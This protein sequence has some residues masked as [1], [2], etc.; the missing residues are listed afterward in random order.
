[1]KSMFSSLKLHQLEATKGLLLLIAI[2]LFVL[3]ALTFS[4][5]N[6]QSERAVA[7]HT[8]TLNE[9]NSAVQQLEKNNQT[10]HDTTIAYLKCI[11]EGLVSSTP[12]DVQPTLNA[13]LTV[14][15]VGMH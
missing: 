5:Q 10:N 3:A 12:A 15:G 7:S 4:Q 13:C 6:R 11:V 8:Q 9:I 1:M 2:V 14:S